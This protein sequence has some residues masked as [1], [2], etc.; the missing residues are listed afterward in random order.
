MIML[1]IIIIIII[2]YCFLGN[3]QSFQNDLWYLCPN[4][5]DKKLKIKI[6]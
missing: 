3:F 4:L 6:F 2:I 5:L 1:L